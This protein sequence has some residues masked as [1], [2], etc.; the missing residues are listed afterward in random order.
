MSTAP[1]ET[2]AGPRPPDLEAVRSLMDEAQALGT[3]ALERVVDV[4][5]AS[6][7]S[8]VAMERLLG[9]L[10]EMGVEVHGEDRETPTGS[11]EP[12]TVLADASSS[13]D[14]VRMYLRE[15]GR[16]RLLTGAEEVSLA[17]R[18]ERGDRRAESALIEANLRLVVSIAKRYVGRGVTFLDLIQEGNFG[19]IRAV[20]KFDH[21]RGYRFSTYATWWI[22][23]AISR[24][25][26][27]QAR[28]IR[29]P[30][31]IVEMIN[32]LSRV[33]RHLLGDL[34][35]E[36]TVA[37]IAHELEI[38]PERVREIQKLAQQPTSLQ[39]PMGEN[40]EFGDLIED[41][42]MPSPLG[43]ATV[44]Q[45]REHLDRALT[46]LDPR[47]RKVLEMRFGLSGTEPRTLED[48]GRRFGVTRER[49]RQI[50]NKAL[51]TLRLH[52]EN[53]GLFGFLD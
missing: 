50:E 21:R 37:E 19:L 32:R 16:V 35:R 40:A 45:R 42:A 29:V 27:G 30:A 20:E 28:T 18:I 39:A 43:I 12:P 26:A 2:L 38:T 10:A 13:S 48:V 9:V 24:A 11:I 22:R 7:L 4:A 49:I 52:G 15:I 3:V 47:S 6:E 1:V 51:G 53:E 31:H 33:E 41:R 14:P 17:K 46:R 8:D 34:G 44:I 36:P 23:Q 5:H 25:I